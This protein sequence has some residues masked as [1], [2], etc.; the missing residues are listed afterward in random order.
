MIKGRSDSKINLAQ[1]EFIFIFN[2]SVNIVAYEVC[3]IRKLPN[4]V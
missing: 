2:S 3:E 1:A 4:K